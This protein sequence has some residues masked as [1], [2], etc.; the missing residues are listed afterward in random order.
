MRAPTCWG[1]LSTKPG[2]T[3]LLVERGSGPPEPA[4]DV[5]AVE[6]PDI[7]GIGWAMT[8]GDGAGAGATRPDLAK[9]RTAAVFHRREPGA[10]D[11]ECG[12]RGGRRSQPRTSSGPA[13]NEFEDFL[14]GQLPFGVLWLR[15]SGA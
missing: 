5:P 9:H 12:E 1:G 11:G 8:C 6:L 3:E 10:C 13:A 7:C 2:E 4:L 14:R 15:R